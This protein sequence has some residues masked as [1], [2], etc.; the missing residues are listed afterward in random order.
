[1]KILYAI[2]GTGNG[3]ISRARDIIPLLQKKGQLDILI[4]GTQADINLNYDITFK[5]KGL[6]FVFG[7]NGGIDIFKTLRSINIFS[8]IKEIRNLP[9]HEYDIIISD[10]EPISTWACKIKGKKCIGLSHQEAVKNINSPKPVVKDP[11][12]QFI[13]KWYAP[14]SIAYGFH[15]QKYDTNIYY[16]VIRSEIRN[17]IVETL[18]HYTVYLPSYGD[19]LLI[20]FFSKIPHVK[21][22]IFSK[23][24]DKNYNVNNISIRKINNEEFIE[25]MRTCTGMF[26]GA[27]F[28]TPAEALYLQKKLMV[29]PM[30]GQY[31]QH[32][33]AAALEQMGVPVLPELHEEFI[34]KV[35][36][37]VDQNNTISHEEWLDETSAILDHVIEHCK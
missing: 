29:I 19:D 31:E 30:K 3:H 16:P 37:W 6:S 32:C 12:A 17:S 22:H 14:S 9:V 21:W 10:F 23:H 20:K 26:C 11:L 4:S 15:F 34:L 13:M 7:K 35:K 25:S 2:Q 1:M 5:L 27:G 33:N 24:T 18:N 28:E 8:I 36:N